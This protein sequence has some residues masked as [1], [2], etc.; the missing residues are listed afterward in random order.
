MQEIVAI[1]NLVISI[2]ILIMQ[3][4]S[5]K[6]KKPLNRLSSIFIRD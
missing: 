2:I 3:I 1:I 4:L 5:F 6:R